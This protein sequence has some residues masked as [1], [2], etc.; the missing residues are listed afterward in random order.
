MKRI[1]TWCALVTLCLLALPQGNAHEFETLRMSDATPA[2][3]IDDHVVALEMLIAYVLGIDATERDTELTD[4]L[5]DMDTD[6]RITNL[7]RFVGATAGQAGLRV[8]DAASGTEF[9]LG[10]A[11]GVF[12]LW[13]NDGTEAAP[14]WVS[15][16][17]IDLSDGAISSVGQS[18]EVVA[19]TGLVHTD[20]TSERTISIDL[21]NASEGDVLTFDTGAPVWL[22]PAG[23][24]GTGDITAVTAGNGLSGGGYSGD[25]SLAISTQG[26]T[27]GEVLTY[28]GA[29]MSWEPVSGGS[30]Q[31]YAAEGHGSV[32]TTLT[33]AG[34]HDLNLALSLWDYGGVH[35]HVDDRFEAANDAVHAITATVELFK[36]NGDDAGVVF[37]FVFKNGAATQCRTQVSI[38]EALATTWANISCELDLDAGDY[39]TFAGQSYLSNSPDALVTTAS[40]HQVK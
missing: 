23:G 9:K 30:S 38:Y 24:G 11:N 6:G 34:I 3:T 31:V 16:L 40:M 12:Q 7:L 17:T 37:L 39:V 4:A 8:R 19:G 21:T 1:A 35:D 15:V 14:S 33:Y 27:A 26:A 2:N 18:L 5:L 22:P 29:V 20:G 28:T 32:S 10:A 36:Q 25:V 13:R